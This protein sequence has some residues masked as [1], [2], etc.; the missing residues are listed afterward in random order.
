MTNNLLYI[1]VTRAFPAH[2]WRVVPTETLAMAIVQPAAL[3]PMSLMELFRQAAVANAVVAEF[4][5]IWQYS[6][7]V[8]RVET[9]LQNGDLAGASALLAVCPVQFSE[10]TL[11]A[12]QATLAANTLRL[13][14]VLA[15]EQSLPGAPVT[16]PEGITDS[17][18]TA[19]L[20]EAGYTWDGEVW[21]R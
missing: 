3:R 20:N 10:K 2:E 9:A 8:R 18:V 7:Y 1:S 14:D 11:D 15:A 17:D 4:A 13:V 5:A 12:L 19:A 16:A 6:E 21:Q